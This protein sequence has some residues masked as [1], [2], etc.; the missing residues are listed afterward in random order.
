MKMYM[1]SIAVDGQSKALDFYTNKLGFVVKH[2]IPT[3]RTPLANIGI[4]RRMPKEWS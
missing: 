1:K 2:D 4:Q 3:G